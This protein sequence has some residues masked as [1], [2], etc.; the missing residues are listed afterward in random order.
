MQI[1]SGGF[2]HW[3]PASTIFAKRRQKIWRDAS[4]AQDNGRSTA[5]AQ[6]AVE[7][8]NADGNSM[9]IGLGGIERCE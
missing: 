3:N 4:A 5:D 2:W 8:I 6:A 1:A 9:A 7:K